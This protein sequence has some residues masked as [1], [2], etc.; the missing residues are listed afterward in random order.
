[1]GVTI[2]YEGQLNSITDYQT[3]IDKA[4]SFAKINSMEYELFESPSKKLSRVKDEKDWDYEGPVKGIKIQP[5]ENTDP[6]W[7]EFDENYYTQDFCKTQFADIE[8]HIKIID[9]FKQIAQHFKVLTIVDEGEYWETEDPAHLQDLVNDCFYAME[10]AV[11]ENN[12]LTGPLR[13]EDGRII[14]LME[15]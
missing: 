10:E 2:H 14:D 15:E 7:L 9:L 1:M 13:V 12:R 5:S 6:L 3:V 11:K 8:I 4:E